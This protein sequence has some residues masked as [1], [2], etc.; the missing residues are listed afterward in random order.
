MLFLLATFYIALR[1]TARNMYDPYYA[2]WQHT[3]KAPVAAMA[4][5]LAAEFL[6][7]YFAAGYASSSMSMTAPMWYFLVAGI[8]AFLIEV[9]AMTFGPTLVASL[10]GMWRIVVGG[11]VQQT[12]QNVVDY[13][14]SC[15]PSY[16]MKKTSATA[17]GT[18]ATAT[19]PT[20]SAAAQ[21]ANPTTPAAPAGIGPP[22]RDAGCADARAYRSYRSYRNACF[23]G[24]STTGRPDVHAQYDNGQHGNG[25]GAAAAIA[26]RRGFYAGRSSGGR[27]AARPKN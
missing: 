20:A 3:W 26:S 18:T 2:G 10:P 17:S 14:K 1:E 12:P 11:T 15:D 5:W 27:S 9:A 13:V 19:M 7:T 16:G 6:F 21:P 25:C 4:F 22:A 8:W 24:R 23:T